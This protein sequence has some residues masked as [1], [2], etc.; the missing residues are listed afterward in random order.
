MQGLPLETPSHI[1]SQRRTD[2]LCLDCLADIA[3]RAKS[4]IRCESCAK[5]QKGDRKGQ[6]ERRKVSGAKARSDRLYKLRHPEKRKASKHAYRKREAIQ[7]GNERLLVQAFKQ[8]RSEVVSE[9]QDSRIEKAWVKVAKSVEKKHRVLAYRKRYRAANLE[10]LRTEERERTR[11]RTPERKATLRVRRRHRELLFAP[12][13]N[14]WKARRFEQQAGMCGGCQKRFPAASSLTIDHIL[15][16]SKGG[17]NS[18]SNLQLL[19]IDCNR[20]KSDK[21]DSEWRRGVFGM[22]L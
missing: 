4:A 21:G 19:C 17:N 20:I 16:L 7:K 5:K 11:Q 8:Y 13:P 12:I 18:S 1:T 14:G 10:R 2:G 22:L 9:I 6:S 3:H 15:P